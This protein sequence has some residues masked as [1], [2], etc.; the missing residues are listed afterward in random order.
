MTN[1][2]TGMDQNR[3]I[4]GAAGGALL[5]LGLRKRGVL[6]LGM[7]AVGGYLAY[8]AATGNDPVMAAAG[9]SGN[10]TA[11]KP[12]FVEHSVVIDRPAQAVYDFWRK[13]ENLPQIMSHLESV[14]ALDE[15]RS[16]WVAKAPLGT[17]VEWEAEIVNDKPGQRIGWHSLP[18]ATV[19]NAGSVQ[20]ES[21]PNGGT[22]VHVALS[23]RPPAGPLG[24]AVA[25]LF[26]EEPSQQIAEDL[27]KFKAAFEG[28][29][30]N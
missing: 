22:R 15:K 1:S 26:G 27:Q 16:R 28:N 3:M 20:F 14:T 9:L 21:L 12:I 5:L 24:A 30:K 8:R 19:D 10:A 13:L 18:G 2:T 11:A 29:A 4:S 25:K 6:G 7:A 17:H 23:Y